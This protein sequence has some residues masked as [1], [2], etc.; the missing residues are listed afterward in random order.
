MDLNSGAEQVAAAAQNPELMQ[1]LVE[2]AMGQITPED[3]NRQ[4]QNLNGAQGQRVLSALKKKGIKAADLRKQILS[5]KSAQGKALHQL[6][7]SAPLVV[8]V[9]ANK[10]I[11]K[12]VPAG[13]EEDF[14][15]R[16]TGSDPVLAAC[17]RLSSEEN[18]VF[19]CSEAKGKVNKKASRLVGH[20][21]YGDVLFARKEGDL[22]LENFLQLE[23]TY[24]TA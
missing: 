22:T 14:I 15:K 8:L 9:K 23:E 21:V 4:R 1:Q 10:A 11:V 17:S 24:S 12:H 7:E 16:T 3:I 19:I 18:T 2:S 6:R 20:N 13:E 5:S